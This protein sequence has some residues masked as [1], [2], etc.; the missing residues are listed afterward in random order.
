MIERTQIAKEIKTTAAK[1]EMLRA[2]Q[3][4]C[5]KVS[6]QSISRQIIG[7]VYVP[8]SVQVVHDAPL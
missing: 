4:V 8:L 6:R 3:N 1:S 5:G 2:K 7:L